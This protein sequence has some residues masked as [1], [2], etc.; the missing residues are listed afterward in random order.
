MFKAGI[1]NNRFLL[2]KLVLFCIVFSSFFAIKHVVSSSFLQTGDWIEYEVI[3]SSN[4]TNL[5][6]GAW[7]PGH[8]FGNWSVGVGDKISYSITSINNININGSL[9]L[10]NYTFLNVRNVDIASALAISIYPWNGGFFA[11]S[12]DWD[13]IGED[14]V[15]TNTSKTHLSNHEK[16][17]NGSRRYFEVE[18][19][20]TLDYYGQNSRFHY[21][22][23]S[24]ILLDA[25]TSF[26]NYSLEI[27]LINTNLELGSPTKTITVNFIAGSILILSALVI[28]FARR[29]YRQISEF[30]K[31]N[32]S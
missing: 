15:E 28:V 19:F 27:S 2:L 18:L 4:T 8:Y 22:S 3:G 11:N 14:I 29:R 16:I 26:L 6:F 24:G 21:D 1:K 25:S 30:S 7:P 20:N 32:I 10:G 23:I 5:L 9:I 12:S 31:Y 13:Q 17:I